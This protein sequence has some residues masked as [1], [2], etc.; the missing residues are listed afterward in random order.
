MEYRI[1]GRTGLSVSAIGF[2]GSPLGGIFGPID[3]PEALRSVREAL[4]NGINYFD[5]APFYGLTKS[6]ALLG[7]ALAGVPRDSYV[8]ATKIGRYGDR[9]FDFS[10][11]RT[12]SSVDASLQRLGV[13][14]VDIIQCHDIEFGDLN[15]VV[16]ET[17]PALN[18]VVRQGKA[19]FV[20]ITGFPLAIYQ[21]VLERA[22][23]DMVLNYCHYALN[24][25]SLER[26]FPLF[27]E[28]G[29]GVVN[30]SPLSM[31]LLTD[32]GPP[33]WHPANQ[34]IKDTCRRAASYCADRGWNF[35]ELALQFAL[36]NPAIHTTL[37]GMS[38]CEEV[39]R[40]V[41]AASSPPQ[42][43]QLAEIRALL[44]PI[45]NES[46]KSPGQNITDP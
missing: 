46:W 35:A 39:Q 5:T 27:Q 31:G 9:E 25:T 8:L 36:A 43:Q 34:T 23:L 44:A 4:A 26:L 1:L 24:N 3:E 19:R 45:Q 21:P 42:P 18:K 29:L 2:G 40:N 22:P 32:G 13:D 38:T 12:L 6:E 37:V 30:A 28:H 33:P 20:G 10:V 41:R 16:E 15:Q 17:L 7:R 14:Y 11:A